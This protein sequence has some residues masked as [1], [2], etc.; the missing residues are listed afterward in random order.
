MTAMQLIAW[1]QTVS[2]LISAGI[3]VEGQ[4]AE[5]LKMFHSKLSDAELNA[6]AEQVK[7][8]ARVRLAQANRDAGLT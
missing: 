3:M 6:I 5:L 4:I 2:V 1:S 7:S 8:D